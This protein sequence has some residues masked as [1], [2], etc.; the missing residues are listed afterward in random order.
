MKPRCST[1]KAS[2]RKLEANLLTQVREQAALHYPA[3]KT[4]SNALAILDVLAALAD[5]GEA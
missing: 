1:P 5:V 2:W 4:M 3:L